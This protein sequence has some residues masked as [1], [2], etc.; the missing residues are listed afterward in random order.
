MSDQTTRPPV[1]RLEL[2]DHDLRRGLGAV[3][4]LLVDLLREVLARQAVRRFTA[5][6]LSDNQAERL[7]EALRALEGVVAELRDLFGLDHPSGP[8]R[9]ASAPDPRPSDMPADLPTDTESR[10]RT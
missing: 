4:V 7:G 6:S 1:A 2:D 9:N 3:V 5:G 10:R 8:A